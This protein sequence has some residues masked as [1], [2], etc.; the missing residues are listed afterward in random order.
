MR[1][2]INGDCKIVTWCST[3]WEVATSDLRAWPSYDIDSWLLRTNGHPVRT[4]YP[5]RGVKYIPEGVMSYRARSVVSTA[6]RKA[7]GCSQSGLQQ[8]C[9][10]SH[11]CYPNQSPESINAPRLNMC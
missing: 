3:A 5:Q 4:S 2:P 1:P 8:R 11:V 6:E 9:L 10:I 7:M